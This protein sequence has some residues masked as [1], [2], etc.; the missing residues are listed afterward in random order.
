MFGYKQCVYDNF[1][2]I[3]YLKEQD[4]DRYHK[5]P[6]D[7]YC[8]IQSNEPTDL[9]DIHGNYMKK[10]TYS[11][12]S[13][14]QNLKNSGI[15]V[16]ESDFK[17]EV[18]FMHDRYDKVELKPD[19]TKWNI[20]LF[21]IEVASGSQFYD[22]HIIKIRNKKT[23][24]VSDIKLY[25]F[26]VN[27]PTDEFEVWDERESTWKKYK[28]S[29]YVEYDFPASDKALWP[30]NCI[31]CY[32]TKDKKMYTFTTLE[33]EPNADDD[34]ETRPFVEFVY[35]NELIM[36]KK[37]LQWFNKQKFDI[38]S[39]WN[40]EAYDIPYIINRCHRLRALWDVTTE[41]E[42]ALSPLAKMPNE[43]KIFD[44]KLPDVDLGSTWEIPGLYSLDY[45][46]LY[47]MFA[48]HPP[49]SS[50]ALNYVCNMELGQGK[51]EYEGK[52]NETY[53]RKKKRFKH[54]NRDDV[55]LLVDLEGKKKIFPL[56]IEYAYDT[57]VNLDKIFMK[58][59]TSEGYI[60]KYLHNEGRVF[61]DR[62]T[63]HEDW[64]RKEKCYETHLKDGSLY[65]QNTEYENE[66][67]MAK[68]RK[69]RLSNPDVHPF[70]EFHVKAGY[71][72]DYPGRYDWC[73]SFDITSSYP[74][75]IMQFNISPEV[76][77]KHPK[78]EDVESGKVILT[79]VAEVG[80]LRTDD[81][82]IPS[83]AKK[84]FAERKE[85]KRLKAEAAARGDNDAKMRYH[86]IQ[87][88]KK[89]II[90]SL[91]GVCLTDSFH[92][93]NIECARA[94]CR[95][96]RVTL[97]DWLK[98]YLDSYYVSYEIIKDVEKYWGIK[99]K[100]QEK[101]SFTNREACVVHC[102]TDSCYFCIA[103]LH[104]RLV[105]EGIKIETEDEV[106]EFFK[107][108][109]DM[110]TDFFVKVLEYRA[111]TS[112][113]TNKIKFNR[114]NIFSNMFCFAKKLYIGNI[115]DSEGDLYPLKPVEGFASMTDEEKEKLPEH[116]RK[117]PEGPKH[118]I[119]GVPIKRSDMPDF[120]KVA[121]EKLA[122]DIAA[123]MSYTDAQEV[124]E[125]TFQQYKAAGIDVVSSKKSITN[126]K[127]YIPKPIEW[128]TKHG[129]IF[130]KGMIFQAK[131]SLA[132]NYL[133][134]KNKLKLVPINNNT[135]FNYMY[136]K[137]N[138]YNIE[139][140]AFIGSWPDELAK[141]LEV[142]YETMFRKSFVPII[143]KMFQISKWIGEKDSIRI[144]KSGM[145]N[146]FG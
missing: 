82:I 132:Y 22:D 23:K 119:M 61:N 1:K 104:D 114:E 27:Y 80:F 145:F 49:M 96:A 117:H 113:T 54:Y 5:Y 106:R 139:A 3:I 18:K 120:C 83:I 11:D 15:I 86:N 70:E 124:V 24:S 47:K 87:L 58:V 63:H 13:V 93:Y 105:E 29:C 34:P 133:I 62:E 25:D 140:I 33:N 10:L 48:D 146:F 141:I 51:L 36:M 9:K 81:A 135:K 142:D 26:D 88:N 115:I 84:V 76:V 100:N 85:Y 99:L 136:V 143:E 74:H 44:R 60:M 38:I 107:H 144:E 111:K 102:D 45:M 7:Q 19:I 137:P 94:I 12:K 79:D 109:E 20:C 138:D 126:Y 129:L 116:W 78:K 130:D 110:F 67:E 39:G 101:F 14:I 21:D 57:L 17:P 42:R 72:Y 28:D 6:Y 37:F 118:K 69:A 56:I 32:S 68:F 90:N 121:A 98:K 4:D 91:Y 103:E 95:C 59:P 123:G 2:K 50:F 92:L 75:H 43:K 65:Y 16:A 134:A 77:V 53:K 40:S 128:Y 52:I 127:K 64:W 41:F 66:C 71:C 97:R 55:W 108:A 31:S 8:Y 122:F 112:K 125:Q 30:I 89:N 73:M 35:E 131:V 46:E